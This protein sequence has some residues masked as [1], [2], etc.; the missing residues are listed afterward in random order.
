MS[1]RRILIATPS[2][3]GK[4]DARYHGCVAQMS[5]EAHQN[6]WKLDY[7]V[8][9]TDSI[10]PRARNIL[11]A[12]F[13]ASGCDD[14]LFVDSDVWCDPGSF[15]RIMSHPVDL[16]GGAYPHRGEIEGFVFRPFDDRL[17]FDQNT[18]LM[19]VDAAATGFLRIRRC[20]VEQM[21]AARPDEW[22]NDI[23]AP[24]GMK[25]YNLFDF[26][27]ADHMYWSEDY[28]FCRRYHELGGKAW[29]DPELILHHEGSKIYSGRLGDWLRARYAQ[30][31]AA[32][33]V[34]SPSDAD[35]ARKLLAAE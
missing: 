15:T 2:Y 7:L 10:L 3:S 26:Q 27:L 9:T 33:K 35:E 12:Q 17:F 19:E 32:A 5:V 29:V 4:M 8:R 22:Y 20:V 1:N 14:M 24:E 30:S 28:V 18:G 11:L 6:G 31:Q 21:I 13:M 25:V 34:D 23:T 16:V